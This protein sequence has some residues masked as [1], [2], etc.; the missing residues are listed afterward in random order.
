MMDPYPAPDFVIPG[1]KVGCLPYQA[2]ADSTLECFFSA[3]CLNRTAQMISNLPVASWPKPLNDTTMISFSLHTPVSIIFSNSIID[4][5][6]EFINFTG[7]YDICEPVECTFTTVRRNSIVYLI[8]LLIGL[9]GGLTVGLR[10]IVPLLI[11]TVRSIFNNF[12]QRCLSKRQ[13]QQRI[14]NETGVSI[15]QIR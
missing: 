13:R 8:T 7:Y 4:H 12:K 5:W 14:S 1:M 3:A 11:K 9:Y 6:K 2:L 10:I 15:Q